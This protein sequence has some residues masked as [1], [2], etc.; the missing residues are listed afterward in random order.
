MKSLKLSDAQSRSSLRYSIWGF[1]A[2]IVAW[3]GLSVHGVDTS[4]TWVNPT[5][6]T[7]NTTIPSGD[8]VSAQI[9]RKVD[10]GAYSLYK[11]IPLATAYVDVNLATGT[12]CYEVAVVRQNGLASALS[13]E[14]CKTVDM[15]IPNPVVLQAN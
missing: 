9:Y 15:R 2:A 5:K 11:T 7:D 4:L 3:F 8:L 13:N 10:A 1:L 12:Y 6:F 14:V